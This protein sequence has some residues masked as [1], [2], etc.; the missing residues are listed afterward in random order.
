MTHKISRQEI[1]QAIYS[2]SNG[3]ATGNDW[4][5]AEIFKQNAPTWSEYL[6]N[7]YNK[8]NQDNVSMPDIWKQGVITLIPKSGDP[9]KY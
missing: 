5:P 7:Y 4:I 2:Q 9:K 1:L 3:K 8:I 6:E